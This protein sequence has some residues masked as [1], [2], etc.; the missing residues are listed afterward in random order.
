MIQ[1]DHT[2]L[3]KR[4]TEVVRLVGAGCSSKQIAL[5]L[6]IAPKTVEAYVEHARLKL[7][8]ANRPQLMVTAAARGLLLAG[9]SV[10]SG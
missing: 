3:T 5:E 2:P 6:G 7:G 10:V 4:E 1:D 9:P 8:A